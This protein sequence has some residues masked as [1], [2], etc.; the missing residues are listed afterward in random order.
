MISIFENLTH[1]RDPLRPAIE[2]KQ[3]KSRSEVELRARAVPSQ[4]SFDK[5]VNQA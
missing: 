5:T 1:F 2:L 3:G 4:T